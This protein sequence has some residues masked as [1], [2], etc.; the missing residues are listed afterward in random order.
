MGKTP[1][2]E[3]WL[4]LQGFELA[5]APDE[6]VASWHRVFD[7]AQIDIAAARQSVMFSKPCPPNEHRY[8]IALE[9]GT[10]LRLGLVIR[11]SPKGEYFIMYP[12]DAESNP[13]ASYHLDGTYHHKSYNRKFDTGAKRHRLGAGF[14]GREHLG[15]FYGVF[16]TATPICDP[17][18][19]TAVVRVRGDEVPKG[20]SVIVDLVEPGASPNPLHREGRRLIQEHTFCNGTP[21][22]VIAVVDSPF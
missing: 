12:R 14:K 9:D 1:T 18:N 8:G 17:A 16:S 6:T 19:F 7:K 13:H 3:D 15:L 20:A 22:I 10:E 2:F 11:R 5:G 4:E 21:H